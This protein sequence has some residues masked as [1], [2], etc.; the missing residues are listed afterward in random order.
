MPPSPYLGE[1]PAWAL[2]LDLLEH[3]ATDGPNGEIVVAVEYDALELPEIQE[4]TLMGFLSLQNVGSVESTYHLIENWKEIRAA[5]LASPA[6]KGMLWAPPPELDQPKPPAI[7]RSDVAMFVDYDNMYLTAEKLPGEKLDLGRMMRLWQPFGQRLVVSNLYTSRLAPHLQ[8]PAGAT[9]QGLRDMLDKVDSQ[10]LRRN[11]TLLEFIREGFRPMVLPHRGGNGGR[12]GKD[13]DA[14]MTE[15]IVNC[16]ELIPSLKC[17]ILA[18]HDHSF[19]YMVSRLKRTHPEV[20]I[21]ALVVDISTQIARGADGYV[22]LRSPLVRM[23][24]PLL[25]PNT[26]PP[27]TIVDRLISQPSYRP[28]LAVIRQMAPVLPRAYRDSDYIVSPSYLRN[29][30]YADQAFGV[31]RFISEI[32]TLAVLK[33]FIRLNIIY[34]DEG[35]PQPM[36]REGEESEEAGMGEKVRTHY[37]CNFNHPLLRRL[38]DASEESGATLTQPL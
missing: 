20:Q 9:E 24:N 22:S 35:P 38:L 27:G 15:D 31:S 36:E 19:Q 26:G 37:A 8:F 30:V 14:A 3:D 16:V 5:R 21:I 34:Q 25:S 2:A 18:T 11:Y 17:V 29:L 12:E 33:L 23:I 4:L 13:L 1:R 28:V 6:P 7:P 10:L 32:E